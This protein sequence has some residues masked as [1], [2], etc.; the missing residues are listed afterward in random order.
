MEVRLPYGIFI[1][2]FLT[3]M[4]WAWG[5]ILVA[6]NRPG[7]NLSTR[8]SRATKRPKDFWYCSAFHAKWGF[9]LIRWD[10]PLAVSSSLSRF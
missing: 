3:V 10:L 9:G 1:V 4:A 7:V 8:L 6:Q 2:P 5:K